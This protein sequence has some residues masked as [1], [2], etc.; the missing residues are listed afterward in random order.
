LEKQEQISKDEDIVCSIW[1][2]IAAETRVKSSDLYR[3]LK[4]LTL[5]MA[6]IIA[7]TYLN[8]LEK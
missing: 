2:H 5:K 3:T 8:S 1:K 7:D 4:R 6:Q